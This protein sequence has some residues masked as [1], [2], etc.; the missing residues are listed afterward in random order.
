MLEFILQLWK[1]QTEE[2]QEK[3]NQNLFLKPR[4]DVYQLSI[5]Q[6]LIS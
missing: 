1:F 3:E 5:F 2:K 4:E 6:A